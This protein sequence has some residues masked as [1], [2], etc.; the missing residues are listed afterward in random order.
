M[1]LVLVQLLGALPSQLAPSP[2]PIARK[3]A[4]RELQG[5]SAS[6]PPNPVIQF[7]LNW[8]KKPRRIWEK[9]DSALTPP[10]SPFAVGDQELIMLAKILNPEGKRG[11]RGPGRHSGWGKGGTALEEGTDLPLALDRKVT[12]V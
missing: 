10:S 4:G 11:L 1:P 2:I 8:F 12:P 5:N 6:L 7:F 9:T 3:G